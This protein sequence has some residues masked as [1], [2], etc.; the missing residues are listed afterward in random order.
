MKE[1]SE[2]GR[3]LV[4]KEKE[5]EVLNNVIALVT[6]GGNLRKIYSRIAATVS[7]FTRFPI[8]AIERYLPDDVV[9]EIVG[10]CGLLPEGKGGTVRI[11]VEESLS[12]RVIRTR[13][14]VAVSNAQEW[15]G[16]TNRQLR[17]LKVATFVSVPLMVHRRI[18]G[19]MS[20]GSEEQRRVNRQFIKFLATLG[21]EV[22]R[23]IDRMMFEE[24]LKISEERYRQLFHKMVDTVL[25]VDLAT[26]KIL[27]TNPQATELT[28]YTRAELIG[29]TVFSLHPEEEHAQHRKAFRRLATKGAVTNFRPVHYV[30]K[31]GRIVPAEINARVVSIGGKKLVLGIVRD[32]SEQ[33]KAEAKLASSEQFLRLIV[34]GTQ[35]LFFYVQDTRGVYTYLSPSVRKI[36]GHSVEEWK[37]VFTKYL[38]PN[39]VNA[40]VRAMR[41][42]TLRSGTPAPSYPCEIYVADGRTILLEI[43][44]TPIIKGDKV[45]GIQGVA[46]D[47]TERMRLEQQILESRDYFNR[48]ID[49]TPMGVIVFDAK[50]N[51]VDVNEAWMRLFGAGNKNVVVGRLNLFTSPFLQDGVVQKFVSAAY[52]GQ[53]VDTPSFT[54]NSKTFKPEYAF[55]DKEH[56]VHVKLFPVFDRNSRLVNVVAMMEDVTDRRRL[57]EQLIQSQKMESIGLLAGGIAHD[58]NNILSAI[59]GYSSYLKGVVYQDEKVYAHLDTIERSALRAAELTSQ[60][61]TF[62]RGGTYLVGPMNIHDLIE[63]TVRLLRASIGKSIAIETD[64]AASSPII[65]GD[66]SQMQ[67]V[68]MNLCVNARDAMPQGGTLKISTRRINKPDA[69]LLSRKGEYTTPYIRVAIA[70]TGIGIDDSIRGRIFEPFF[71]TKEKGKGT[72]LGLATVYGIIEHHGGFIDFQ[73]R[74]GVGTTFFIYLPT[75]DKPPVV[76]APEQQR[77]TGGQ[78]TI[79]IVD[80]E[81]MIR[82]LV[83]DILA[84]KGYNV[85]AAPDGATA[86]TMY[87]E[88]WRSIDLVILDMIMPGMTG[89]E[90]MEKLK[91][92]NPNVRAILSTGYSEDDRARDLMALGVKVFLQK[93]YRTEALSIAVRKVLDEK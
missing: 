74:V 40:V 31:D 50:G 32:I 9:L 45:V 57:E 39:P 25:I 60:L 53:I 65:V 16:Y 51:A 2:N 20:L 48:L 61:L 30:R 93:P 78:E 33:V 90:T 7:R 87:K 58:F 43:N 83:K 92:I 55:N 49:Q 26:G 91:E 76:P 38:T 75:A 11:P 89:R 62:A 29:R 10:H 4:R 13:K 88:N 85:L 15:N 56:T 24:H 64:L 3:K 22:A 68:L 21:T 71:T 77:P 19:A 52:A 37:D 41:E 46:R 66:G 81:D 79:F 17:N 42:E 12:G 23:L 8:V 72:G 84:S 86:V 67:Q 5:L 14:P 82:A 6:Q 69:Y 1:S 54:I 36:T 34:E 47:I 27:D 70:D 18:F 59:L 28:G 73:S 63:E 44:E 35:D 80:D